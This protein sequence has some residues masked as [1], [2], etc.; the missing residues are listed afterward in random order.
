M[1]FTNRIL[2]TEQ[3]EAL[4]PKKGDIIEHEGIEYLAEEIGM[5]YIVATMTSNP[6][7]QRFLKSS[8]C[9][10]VLAVNPPVESSVDLVEEFPGLA[11]R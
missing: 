2:D 8:E 9:R 1:R 5:R 6:A 3:L 7:A 10:K 11:R 4:R